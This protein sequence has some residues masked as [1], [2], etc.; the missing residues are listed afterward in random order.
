MSLTGDLYGNS[1]LDE[2]WHLMNQMIKYYKFGFG[3]VTE[4]VNEELRAGTMS[5]SEAINIVEKF[6]GACSDK[7]IANFCTYIDISV[8][9]FWAQVH[10]SVNRDLF[11]IELD[12]SIRRKFKVGVGL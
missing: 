12:G 9:E 5:R 1:N 4:C 10:S 7:Y 8:K 2:D 3:K 6:D 11:E